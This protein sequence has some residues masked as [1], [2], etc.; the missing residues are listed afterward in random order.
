MV[1]VRCVITAVA[2]LIPA[3][4][5]A[6]TVQPD[7]SPAHVP[8]LVEVP[9]LDSEDPLDRRVAEIAAAS[10]NRQGVRVVSGEEDA[11]LRES[12]ADLE[13]LASSD[14]E[15]AIEVLRR[16]SGDF[17]VSLGVRG[18]LDLPEVIYG[19]ETFAAEFEVLATLIRTLDGSVVQTASAA[20]S[21]RRGSSEQAS[22]AA[23]A[24]A[25]EQSMGRLVDRL[26]TAA[27]DA[28]R[29]VELVFVGAG[30]PQDS[31]RGSLAARL[32]ESKQIELAGAVL[33]IE[34]PPADSLL[35]SAL[36]ESG[37]MVVGRS[38]G[39]WLVEPKQQ[40]TAAL[41]WWLSAS[42]GVVIVVGV[43]LLVRKRRVAF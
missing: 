31:L 14:R 15:R 35:A 11:R 39:V 6:G 40:S 9:G 33:R 1:Q 3:S 43:L 29:G 8:F 5:L 22:E 2:V 18:A 10:L 38:V 21:A 41:G 30:T 34:P 37:W 42:L 20:A 19:I 12:Q 4:S 25:V 36:D 32:P 17:I 24:E 26:R 13:F 7:R 28:A 23:L 16:R 27:L